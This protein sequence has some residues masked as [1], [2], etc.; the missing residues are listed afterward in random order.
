MDSTHI[1]IWRQQ[2][3]LS[4][5]SILQGH[6]EAQSFSTLEPAAFICL[7]GEK[8]PEENTL[9]LLDNISCQVEEYL[10]LTIGILECGIFIT[11]EKAETDFDGQFDT[12]KARK[13]FL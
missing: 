4:G 8:E 6:W 10:T 9:L 3:R 13:F 12:T 1:T 5:N 7:W 2:S 11:S